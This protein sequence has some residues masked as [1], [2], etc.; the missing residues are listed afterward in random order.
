[1]TFG[2]SIT[3]K[4]ALKGAITSFYTTITSESK[5]KAGAECVTSLQSAFNTTP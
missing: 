3:M 5:K 1:M 4:S 2:S